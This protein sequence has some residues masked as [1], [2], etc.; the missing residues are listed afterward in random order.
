MQATTS[1]FIL[2]SEAPFTRDRGIMMMLST[3][4][5]ESSPLL[6]E[7]SA[8][9]ILESATF[10]FTTLNV[11]L[12][13]SSGEIPTTLIMAL[14]TVPLIVILSTL[15]CLPWLPWGSV[16]V[17]EALLSRVSR[18]EKGACHI[19]PL[20]SSLASSALLPGDVRVAVSSIPWIG[21]PPLIT[22]GQRS[23]PL[24]VVEVP[25]EVSGGVALPVGLLDVGGAV[26]VVL[27]D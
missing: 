12:L 4:M 18:L 17:Q 26:V 22:D 24:V 15:D 3:M 16:T 25:G 1:T 2:T 21:D 13:P 5:G 8:N 14:D 20:S 27:S 23:A 10:L 11:V 19:K 9:K 7:R 6:F